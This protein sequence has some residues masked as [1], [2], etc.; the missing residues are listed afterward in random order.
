MSPLEPYQFKHLY[1]TPWLEQKTEPPG[2]PEVMP[3]PPAEAPAMPGVD[4]DGGVNAERI[5]QLANS[6]YPLG[7]TPQMVYGEDVNIPLPFTKKKIH[8]GGERMD[9]L[10]SAIAAAAGNAY[11]P[12][13]DTGGQ[14]LK[15]FLQGYSGIRSKDYATRKAEYEKRVAEAKSQKEARDKFLAQL[16]VAG[17]TASMKPKAGE[18]PSTSILVT[19]EVIASAKKNGINI[20][21]GLLGSYVPTTSLVRKPEKPS[22]EGERL[23]LQRSEF[24]YNKARDF[25][26]SDPYKLHNG[27]S[28]AYAKILELTNP[29]N[30]NAVMDDAVANVINNIMDPTSATLISEARRWTGGI[31]IVNNLRT[32]IQEVRGKGKM[33][34]EQRMKL[35]NL[36]RIVYKQSRG[37][38]T[39]YRDQSLRSKN[40]SITDIADI[41][42]VTEDIIPLGQHTEASSRVDADLGKVTPVTPP[43]RRL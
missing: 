23:E 19:P 8:I 20:S 28:N 21:E 11:V 6:L 42:E 17:Y 36:A 5:R 16:G 18:K 35:R 43:R 41:P 30:A 27:I 26:N 14:L 29:K 34:D 31:G 37:S 24:T 9:R 32:M 12:G 33:T 4:V 3:E 39:N 25:Q 40:L 1:Q 10:A 2:S 13:S 7:N 22:L 15:G 38:Y